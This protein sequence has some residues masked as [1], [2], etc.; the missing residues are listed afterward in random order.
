MQLPDRPVMSSNVEAADWIRARLSSPE[1][2]IVTS[3]IPAGFEAYARVLHPAQLPEDHHELVRW[4]EVSRWSG[5]AMHDHVQWH[6]IALP[7]VAPSTAP[8]WRSQGPRAGAPFVDDVTVLVEHLTG[9]TSTPDS[10]DFG[11]WS[12]YLGGAAVMYTSSGAP[13]E[14]LPPPPQPSRLVQLP[15]R[16][17]ALFQGPLSCA[18]S[19]T[20]VS[21]RHVATANLWWPA[22]HSWCVASEIDLSWTYVGGSTEL[23]RRVL[24]DERLEALPALP[25]D[26]S[27]LNVI[28][29]L[30]ELI[31]Q[32][33]NQVL[34]SGS[35]SLSL[36]RGTVQVT[37]RKPAVLRHGL[38]TS[39]T[40]GANG[41]SSGESP[42]RT[43]DRDHLRLQIH[44]EVQRAVL[45]LVAA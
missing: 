32:T 21:H 34:A 41:V 27:C 12:G 42:V 7:R 39:T 15:W 28:G 10:C 20:G 9:A 37:W 36:S 5:V 25:G 3:I 30:A 26:S 38:I 40:T 17:Y 33:T 24:D 23:I 35:A 16:D 11:V 1:R 18:T 44:H 43:R 19:F 8:P 2:Y 6:E 13:P 4:S 14:R 45:G 31:E 22:D 29:W